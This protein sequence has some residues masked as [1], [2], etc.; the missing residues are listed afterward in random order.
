MVNRR[1]F[2]T[3][4][5]GATVASQRISSTP[6]GAAAGTDSLNPYQDFFDEELEYVGTRK[7]EP[8]PRKRR[9]EDLFGDIADIAD[10]DELG[11]VYYGFDFE[12]NL[13]KKARCEEEMDRELIERILAIRAAN[14][15]KATD[16]SKRTKLEQLEAL[17]KFKKQNLSE[18][19]PNWPSIPLL[20]DNRE[21]I[22]VRM[23]SEAF[24]ANQL[25]D[26]NFRRGYANLLGENADTVW[27][28]AQ[29]IVQ[30]RMTGSTADVQA[31]NE[32]MNDLQIG[33][34]TT[35]SMKPKSD[36]LWVDKYRPQGYFDLLSDESTNRNLLTWL[37]MWDKMVFHQ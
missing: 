25:K 2:G 5:P 22:H 9:L 26:I 10:D 28:E 36:R 14:R 27:D 12:D 3:P 15:A 31:A 20:G 29:A 7:D 17:Q 6:F 13:R 8:N 19:Y 33:D 35:A 21:R 32:H 11:K 37:K 1:L 30:K 34:V 18:S 16:R 24:E 23:H 4:A